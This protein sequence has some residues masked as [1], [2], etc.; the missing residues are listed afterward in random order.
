M[1]GTMLNGYL[2]IKE[3]EED[4]TTKSGIFVPSTVE[5]GD[6]KRYT[7][8]ESCYIEENSPGYNLCNVKLNKG[9]IVVV[10][11]NDCIPLKVDNNDMFVVHR[12]KIIRNEY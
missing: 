3:V 11:K 10:N 5:Q 1:N 7:L 9:S 4:K 2:L 6:L 12:D 8:M